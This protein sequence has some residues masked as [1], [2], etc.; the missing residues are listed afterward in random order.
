MSKNV[1]LGPIG[2]VGPKFEPPIF[3]MKIIEL[4]PRHNPI[5]LIGKI[6]TQTWENGKKPNFGVDLGS[7][8]PNLGPQFFFVGFTSMMFDIVASYHCMQ[9]QWRPMSQTQ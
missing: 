6:K 7:F 3:L 5:Q 1:I 4:V 9:F 2:L 8:D